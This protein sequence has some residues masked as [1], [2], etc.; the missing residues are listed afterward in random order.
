VNENEGAGIFLPGD[1]E[2]LGPD[3]APVQMEARTV[4]LD[5]V[6]ALGGDNVLDAIHKIQELR[7]LREPSGTIVVAPGQVTE[8]LLIE[9]A[10]FNAERY[11]GSELDESAARRITDAVKKRWR[12]AQKRLKQTGGK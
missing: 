8:N 11:Q 4:G 7:R 9:V 1:K 3:G 10:L 2:V 6:E 5:L 12:R